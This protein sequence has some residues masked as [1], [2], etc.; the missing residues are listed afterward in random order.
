MKNHTIE[1]TLGIKNASSLYDYLDTKTRQY[2]AYVTN[3]P[4]N[5]ADALATL[6]N[7]SANFVIAQLMAIHSLKAGA[8][9]YG[10]V[11]FEMMRSATA[12][13]GELTICQAHRLQFKNFTWR[14]QL[15]D[16]VFLKECT[17]HKGTYTLVAPGNSRIDITT[18][19]DLTTFD[20]TNLARLPAGHNSELFLKQCV[21][22]K[23]RTNILKSRNPFQKHYP[24]SRRLGF[25]LHKSSLTVG[26]LD[27]LADKIR[28]NLHL[29]LTE[30][31]LMNYCLVAPIGGLTPFI[32]TETVIDKRFRKYRVSSEYTPSFNITVIDKTFYFEI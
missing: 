15:S 11:S 19:G 10:L 14:D 6:N 28:T 21:L 18:N 7:S 27:H 17:R 5:D 12:A 30:D 9:T 8:A 4:L 23:L 16:L 31:D 1:N 2:L 3:S 25:S 20:F 29:L 13:L 22:E 24:D 26:N 32:V